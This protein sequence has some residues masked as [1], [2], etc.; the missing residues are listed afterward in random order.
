MRVD[1]RLADWLWERWCATDDADTLQ[2]VA[3]EL[4]ALLS[5]AMACEEWA[6]YPVV[7]REAA[8]GELLAQQL[9][10]E[11][12]VLK[13][14]LYKLEG[15]T[16]NDEG[17]GRYVSW[18]YSQHAQHAEREERELIPLLQ[19]KSQEQLRLMAVEYH[20]ARAMAPTRSVIPRSSPPRV[21]VK[22]LASPAS[23]PLL[24][25]GAGRVI[26]CTRRRPCSG[27]RPS[28]PS[29]QTADKRRRQ[30]RACSYS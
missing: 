17:F 8:N 22:R 3:S 18:T 21:A 15:L 16:V 13:G 19:R 25:R 23:C 10:K 24:L 7:R 30:R 14:A 27:S 20:V 5:T 6:V 9:M 4:R 12:F 2:R 29:H 1:H 26:G 11:H 28:W